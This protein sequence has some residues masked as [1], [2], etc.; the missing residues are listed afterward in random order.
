MLVVYRLFF[1]LAFVVSNG[2]TN[3]QQTEVL[4]QVKITGMANQRDVLYL[5][6][7]YIEQ[8][9]AIDSVRISSDTT[10][11]FPVRLHLSGLYSIRLKSEKEN[12]A[13][14][15][16]SPTEKRVGIICNYVQLLNGMAEVE[17]SAEN[18]AYASLIALNSNY[19]SK[20]KEI[21][22]TLERLHPYLSNYKMQ[23]TRLEELVEIEHK[24]HN[25]DLLAF[26]LRYPA[27]FSAQ[28][29]AP[30]AKTP[31]R[32]E[33]HAKELFDSYRSFLHVH[34]FDSTNTND[35]RV[36]NHYAFMDKVT[37]YLSQYTDKTSDGAKAGI[38]VIMN[39]LA[40]ND[41]VNGAVY[42][43]LL[44]VFLKHKS[45]PLIKHLT[46]RHPNGCSLNLSV[47]ELRKLNTIQSTTIGSRAPDLLLYDQNGKVQ[48]L[49]EHCGRNK[50]TILLFW[51]SWCSRC[52]KEVPEIEKLFQQYRKKGVGLFTVS[53]DEKKEDWVKAL[54][55]H[56]LSGTNVCEQVPFKSSKVLQDYGISTTP[57]VFVID[58]TGKI[59]LKN[60]YGQQLNSQIEV[61]VSQ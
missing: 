58:K 27:T 18:T 59:L 13:E 4:V 29:L 50:V 47:E 48:S 37:E 33:A 28:V 24:K 34:Y 14:F 38:D 52:K 26:Q 54:T 32:E 31:T 56:P 61:L 15:I 43:S 60:I 42:T 30:L 35:T 10:V 44:R 6:R 25:I 19:I 12:Q 7:F 11:T 39:V 17:S 8:F 1:F 22:E 55:A 57:A 5:N 53:L 3:A 51:I 46:D 23:V 45:E 9:T 20:R 36:L 21:E 40:Q 41:E 16:L 2:L 49:Y